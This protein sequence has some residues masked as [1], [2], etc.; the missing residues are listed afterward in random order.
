MG[1][2]LQ[3][4]KNTRG[5]KKN[6][7]LEL[8][9]LEVKFNL[10]EVEDLK[11]ELDKFNKFKEEEAKEKKKLTIGYSRN[12][13]HLHVMPRRHKETSKDVNDKKRA[14]KFLCRT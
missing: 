8:I 3:T 2:R 5:A 9:L 11:D 13:S 12:Y 1:N 7:A 10:E 6:A 4:S 14:F